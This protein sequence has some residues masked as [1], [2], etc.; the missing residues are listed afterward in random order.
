MAKKQAQPANQ[1]DLS[2]F[3]ALFSE[4]LDRVNG[5]TG[6][7]A[8]AD[9]T[10]PDNPVSVGARVPEAAEWSAAMIEGATRSGDRWLKHTLSPR[11]NPVTA[12]IAADQKRKD[13]LA[14][15]E[16]LG[17]WLASM[18]RVDVDAMYATIEAVGPGGYTGGIEA[19]R[20]KI[21]GKIE[22]LRPQVLALAETID[23]MPDGTDAQREAKMVAA[24]RGMIAIGAKLRGITPK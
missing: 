9:L 15:A 2:N 19:R 20:G 3:E 10:L 8:P 13:K 24:R 1:V 17:K 21:A 12:A 23:K 18:N 11:K 16:R 4:I 22:R 14:E 7:N 5:S 6:A